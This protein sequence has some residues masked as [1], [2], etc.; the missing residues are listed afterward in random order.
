MSENC[1]LISKV[2]QVTYIVSVS[3]HVGFRQ[4]L[5]VLVFFLKESPASGMS[6]IL[7]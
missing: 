5:M 4:P 2:I 3:F 7:T 1:L 6:L